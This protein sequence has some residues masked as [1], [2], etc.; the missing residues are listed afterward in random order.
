MENTPQG[1]RTVN[2]LLQETERCDLSLSKQSRIN[3]TEV[4][5]DHLTRVFTKLM[6]Q[7]R[8]HDAVKWITSRQSGG[9]LHPNSTLTVNGEELTVF[10]ILQ[11]KHPNY[12]DPH[13]DSLMAI[14][15]NLPLM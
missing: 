1:T 6:L 10:E 11:T 2:I 13:P 8:I 9:V 5:Q 15:S 4:N 7:G 12:Q 3:N 14:P